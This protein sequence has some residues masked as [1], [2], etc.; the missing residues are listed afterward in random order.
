MTVVATK[1]PD[2][3]GYATRFDV[4]CSDGRTIKHSAFKHQDTQ[5]VQLV[6]QHQ[7]DSP[8]NVLGHAFLYQREDGVYTEAFFNETQAAKDAKELVRHG[9]VKALSI[10]ANKLRQEGGDVV[11]GNIIEVSLVYKGAND[12]AVI[13]DVNLQHAADGTDTMIGE[14]II[15]SG[16]EFTISHADSADKADEAD[17][18]SGDGE[19]VSDVVDSMT[20][21]QKKVLYALVVDASGDKKF[22]H[23]D[24][25]S[26][27][28]LHSDEDDEE[29]SVNEVKESLT[30]TQKEVF[31]ALVEEAGKSDD[32]SDDSDD[33]NTNSEEA[34]ESTDSTDSDDN[35]SDESTDSEDSEKLQHNQEGSANMSKYSAF[36]N[37]ATGGTAVKDR[38]T[39]THSDVL[40]LNGLAESTGS[41]KKAYDQFSLN[42]ADYGIENIDI[43]FPDARVSSQTPELISR[44]T[45]WVSKVLGATKHA[46]FAK[47]KTILADLTAEEARAKGYVTGALKKEEVVV[48]L[49]RSTSPATIYKKQKLDRDNVID[50]TDI[51]IISWLKWE[52][53]FMLNEE[54]ARA[55][56]IGDGRTVGHADKI[57]DPQGQTDGLGIRSVANDHELYAHKVELAANVAPDVM[58]DEITRART[59]YRGSG[60]PTFYTTDAVLTE[61]LLLKDK[62]GR[63]LYETEASLAAAIR[64]KEIVPVEPMGEDPTLLGIIVNLID[65]TVGTNKGGEITSFEQFDIDFN[66][67]KY[68]M[69]TRMSGALTKPKSALVITRD[70]GTVATATAPTFV[71]GTNTLTIPTTTGVNYVID[72]SVVPAGDIVIEETTD[73]YAEPK[74]GF[75]LA[76][77]ST[78]HWVFTYT[79]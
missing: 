27:I 8:S 46:P 60:S 63:R 66:Q 47:I 67:Y 48:L 64:V 13:M 21:K 4:E 1:I 37:G 55:I 50:I 45:E 10:F 31:E 19:S 69:E 56:L 58:I 30:P 29:V 23:G 20:P 51:D 57:K 6:W 76:P 22:A 18:S 28:I 59:N 62:M 79:A 16:E 2:F 17:T 33:S 38:Y 40:E 73:V 43:L 71:T 53:R 24:A 78:R 25:D 5:Q 49:Q 3:T 68:L 61:M 39:L 77:L 72:G 9:D 42:H 52:I 41:Y 12:Q 75:Y 14:V 32:E 54:I 11:H 15:Y 36:E 65:Y 26:D 34:D 35:T 74:V 70:A 44:Q 7:H